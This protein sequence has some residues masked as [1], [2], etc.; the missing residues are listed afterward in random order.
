MNLTR[1]RI[2]YPPRPPIESFKS[3][4]IIEIPDTPERPQFYTFAEFEE[5][6]NKLYA[7]HVELNTQYEDNLKK[8][9]M[10]LADKIEWP[11]FFDQLARVISIWEQ[12]K[13]HDETLKPIVRKWEKRKGEIALSCQSVKRSS[14][15]PIKRLY[16]IVN[17]LSDFDHRRVAL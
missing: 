11:L 13:T 2:A 1:P 9:L 8:A 12:L 3:T 14:S 6:R 17:D 15:D 4:P 5:E 10:Y 7:L 16:D